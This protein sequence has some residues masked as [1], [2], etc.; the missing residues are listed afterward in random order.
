[1]IRSPA[2]FRV[3]ALTSALMALGACRS[4]FT[5][6]PDSLVGTYIAPH[7][8]VT[9][10]G[11]APMDL[12]ANGATLKIA[13]A[14]DNT[15]SGTLFIPSGVTGGAPLQASMVGA[16]V[17]TGDVVTFQQTADTFVRDLRWTVYSQ[18][19]VVDTQAVDRVIFSVTLERR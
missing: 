2:R 12:V 18:T 4:D 7:I 13:I 8:F 5:S 3:L 11:G 14:E 17:R 9:P 1:M 15:T 19:L 10:I 16:V 6:G